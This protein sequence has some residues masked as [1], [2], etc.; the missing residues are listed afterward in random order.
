VRDLEQFVNKAEW[1][2]NAMAPHG[3]F[4]VTA[5]VTEANFEVLKGVE[6]RLADKGVPFK[7]QVMQEDDVYVRYPD[8]MEKY[9]R[10]RLDD[11]IAQTR[12]KN[13][14]GRICHTGRLFFTV[15]V[16]GECTRCYNVQPRILLG[17]VLRGTFSLF[18]ESK[19]CLASKCTC[20]VP[21][22]RNMIEY[23]TRAGR[24]RVYTEYLAGTVSNAV[25]WATRKK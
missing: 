9:L 2:N 10:G 22:N 23:R 15:D 18:R 21:A 12:G 11:N 6:E 20:T 7:Y 16:H 17:N 13:F 25:Y 5:V 14:F 4:K 19:P 1:F 24:A 3:Y 8:S